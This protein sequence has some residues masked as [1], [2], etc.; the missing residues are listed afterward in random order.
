MRPDNS[1]SLSMH[2]FILAMDDTSSSKTHSDGV[3]IHRTISCVGR[4]SDDGPQARVLIMDIP[5][6]RYWKMRRS[7]GSKDTSKA[8]S[9]DNITQ[10][11]AS[12]A[13]EPNSI[14]AS[15]AEFDLTALIDV[16]PEKDEDLIDA[17]KIL[18]FYRAWRADTLGPG[19]LMLGMESQSSRSASICLAHANHPK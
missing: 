12:G 15:N 9:R 5:K 2:L 11:G 8:V 7:R 1:Y 19:T 6:G 17:V 16:P 13:A 18:E 4:D 3:A 10:G 14:E